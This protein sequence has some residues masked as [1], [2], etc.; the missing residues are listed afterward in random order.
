M[1]KEMARP[2]VSVSIANEI[3]TT[4][5][6][7]VKDYSYEVPTSAN[8]NNLETIETKGFKGGNVP[9]MMGG[10]GRSS[11]SSDDSTLDSD[12]TISGINAYA[13]ISGVQNESM[14]VHKYKACASKMFPISY[15]AQPPH[16]TP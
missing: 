8:S 16:S 12:I 9:S 3:A 11:S 4:Y 2:S 14:S 15:R 6:D 5:T 7:Y 1:F 10:F 13:Y